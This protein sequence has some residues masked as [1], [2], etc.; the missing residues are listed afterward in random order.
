MTTANN[1]KVGDVIKGTGLKVLSVN[2]DMSSTTSQHIDA[3]VDV[4]VDER[5]KKVEK[6]K[7]IL[8]TTNNNIVELEF[9]KPDGTIASYHWR[10]DMVVE[11]SGEI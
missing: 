11:L 2:P 4:L 1:L 7:A 9:L 8:Y 5:T 3:E 6:R 10:K